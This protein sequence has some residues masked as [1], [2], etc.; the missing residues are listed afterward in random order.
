MNRSAHNP[1]ELLSLLENYS[2][3]LTRLLA[4]QPHVLDSFHNA[5]AEHFCQNIIDDITR[6]QCE[7]I[8]NYAA[9]HYL[10]QCKQQISL[11]IA[12]ADISGEW[13]LKQVTYMLS[14]FADAVT[15]YA[16]E[17]SLRA[18]VPKA[19]LSETPVS[20]DCGIVILG[21]GKLGGYEL[22]YS[23]DIDIIAIYDPERLDYLTPP[24]RGR[25][26]ARIIQQVASLLQDRTDHGYVFRVDLRLR[27]DPA[28]TA[29]AVSLDTATHYYERVGQNWERAAMIKARIIAGDMT[30]GQKFLHALQPFIW[31]N[32]LDFAAIDDIL[33]IK[34]QMQATQEPDITLPSHHLK[35]GYGGIREIEFLV[36]IYQLI[37]GGRVTELRIR[38]TCEGLELLTQQGLISAATNDALQSAYQLLRLV[39]HR[40]QM[41]N[42]QQTHSLPEN[43]QGFAELAIFC[44]FT[45]A[46]DFKD[47][48]LMHL[49]NV[50]SIFTE[51][52]A[53]S[54][55]LGS[56]GKLVF[57]GVDHDAH[58]LD[59]LSQMGFDNAESISTAIQLWHKGSKKS[60]RTKKARELLT[61]LV[62]DILHALA[63]TVNP[64][65]A[66]KRF[67]EFLDALP[68]GVQLFSLFQSNTALLTLIARIVGNAPILATRLSRYPQML[69]LIVQ[70]H[71]N[72]LSTLSGSLKKDLS[73]WLTLARNEEEI[74]HYFCMFKLEKEFVVATQLLQQAIT[75][76][77][78][79]RYLSLLADTM[80][81]KA[82]ELVAAQLNEKYHVQP[83]LRF[84]IIALGKLGTKSLMIGS[85]LDV[86]CIYD[87]MS[88]REHDYYHRLT[89]RVIRLLSYPTKEGPLYEMDTQLRPFG[90]QGAVAVQLQGFIR[91]YND[92]AWLV[93]N[94]ALVQA[95]IVMTSKAMK[96][97]I[98]KALRVAQ[99]VGQPYREIIRNIHDVRAKINHQYHSTNP[100]DIKYISGGMMDIQWILKALLARQRQDIPYPDKIHITSNQITW[101]YDCRILTAQQASTMRKAYRLYH[102]TL[103]YLRLYQQT[104]IQDHEMSES[105]KLLLADVTKIHDF[106]KLRQKLLRTQARIYQLYEQLDE[107]V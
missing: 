83:K 74:I 49:N 20:R 47:T 27:P 99:Y 95:R 80:I 101:L 90:A 17:H 13:T 7:D 68:S 48:L 91:Y 71:A 23:S 60:T 10:R 33:S 3:Y 30:L 22:N 92:S 28:S 65:Q 58:T 70:R 76:R 106:A 2:P 97:D 8:S 32:H 82:V 42:D 52:F 85:D 100:W 89:T 18:A 79:S 5:D 64:D 56:A 53:E 31:R 6:R 102:T 59:T 24:A 77:A 69:D 11:M 87:A 61:E 37:W 36:Q 12:L 29:L 105:F 55:P 34:R 67:D 16:L 54:H 72:P 66:F 94:L 9:R 45:T 14:L 98:A 57:T 26:A 40:L 44:G 104:H 73:D 19:M 63:S 38:A 107:W 15:Q 35:T 103:S 93:E 21:M 1:E 50:H 75:P 86:M 43:E 25:F 96:P 78:A 88:E 41:R 81:R 62:P 46:V 39:E 51:A 4:L 84:C